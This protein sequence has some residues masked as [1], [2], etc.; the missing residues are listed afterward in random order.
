MKEEPQPSPSVPSPVRARRADGE[1]LLAAQRQ[2][3]EQVGRAGESSEAI[4]GALRQVANAANEALEEAGAGL[5]GSRELEGI[6]EKAGRRSESVANRVHEFQQLARK[7]LSEVQ[8]LVGGVQTF[9]GENLRILDQAKALGSLTAEIDQKVGGVVASSEQI[10]LLALNAVIAANRAGR[11]G[12]AFS[13]VAN[14]V[15]TLAERSSVSAGEIR[16]LA[17]S[18]QSEV[19]AVLDS[20]EEIRVCSD[21]EIARSEQVLKELRQ[22]EGEAVAVHLDCQRVHAHAQEVEPVVEAMRRSAER[23]Q[24]SAE[25]FSRRIR[26]ALAASE[27]QRECFG[28]M[29]FPLEAIKEAAKLLIVEGGPGD[30]EGA[31][32]QVAMALE[33]VAEMVEGVERATRDAFAGI[34]EIAEVAAREVEQVRWTPQEKERTQR[35]VTALLQDAELL[36]EKVGALEGR[37]EGQVLAE[38][39]AFVRGAGQSSERIRGVLGRIQGLRSQTRRI[40]KI[41]WEISLVIQETNVMAFNGSVE[42]VRAGQFGRSFSQVAEDVRELARESI[43]AADRIQDAVQEIQ[44]HLGSMIGRLAEVGDRSRQIA[45]SSRSTLQGLEFARHHFQ[46]FHE[47]IRVFEGIGGELDRSMQAVSSGIETM[48]RSLEGVAKTAASSRREA[49]EQMKAIEALS[50]RVTEIRGIGFPG[51]PAAGGAG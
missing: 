16:T 18:I 10:T 43:Q 3:R 47:E 35:P 31:S 22:A 21:G 1:R 8:A 4:L 27:T 13:V 19:R 2:F 25:E 48:I 12:R 9:L 24:S 14:E 42:A 20:I 50:D 26:K 51:A 36:R 30:L 41:A 39:E 11:F 40:Q 6:V 29:E 23:I 46:A 44:E 7:T 28:T 32:A 49:R 37:F 33:G 15:Q 34:H 17:S 5:E 38:L 45:E